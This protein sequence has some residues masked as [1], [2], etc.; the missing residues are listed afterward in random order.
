MS[1]AL[2]ITHPEPSGVRRAGGKLLSVLVGV[3]FTFV[4]FWI[5]ATFAQNP[6][7]KPAIEMDTLRAISLPFDP[8][9]PPKLTPPT[10]TEAP[11]TVTGFEASASDSPVKVVAIPPDILDMLPPPPAAP[12]ANIHVGKLYTEFKPQIDLTVSEK[13]IYQTSEVDESPHALTRPIRRIPDYVTNG[14][15]RLS[16]VVI[17]VIDPKGLPKSIKLASS[18][19]IPEFDEIILKS[20]KDWTFSP[21]VKKGKRVNCVV[22]QPINFAASPG[23]LFGT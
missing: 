3:G 1:S 10:P 8:P 16:M 17:V 13:R 9:P 6:S 22:E 11:V 21:A 18:S 12:P 15:V 23:T 19:G 5:V 2:T 4:L 20:I 14:A 7:A